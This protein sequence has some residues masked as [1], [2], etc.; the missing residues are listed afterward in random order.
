MCCNHRQDL[1]TALC[2]AFDGGDIGREAVFA[3]ESVQEGAVVADQAGLPIP[4]PFR[5]RFDPGEKR[6]DLQPALPDVRF[7]VAVHSGDQ[8][9]SDGV[10]NRDQVL[11]DDKSQRSTPNK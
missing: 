8:V 2:Q 1:G 11:R 7:G 3:L 9:L 10:V 4:T 6:S 5:R